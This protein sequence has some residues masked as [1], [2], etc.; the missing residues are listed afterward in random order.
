MTLLL[1][2]VLD[3]YCWDNSPT[4]G[5]MEAEAQGGNTVPVSQGVALPAGSYASFEPQPTSRL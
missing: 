3:S 2:L 1:Y 5:T 4:F